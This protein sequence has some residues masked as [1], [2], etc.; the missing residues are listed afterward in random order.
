MRQIT[1]PIYEEITRDVRI[2]ETELSRDVKENLEKEYTLYEREG[3]GERE[4]QGMRGKRD[5]RRRER[6]KGG[7]ERGVVK[8]G[9]ERGLRVAKEGTEKGQELKEERERGKRIYLCI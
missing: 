6:R 4:W 8:G 5:T 2:H 7:C 1:Q 3:E 9:C